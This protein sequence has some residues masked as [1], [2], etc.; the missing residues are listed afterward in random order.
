MY[1]T[2]TGYPRKRFLVLEKGSGDHL[3]SIGATDL[4]D[5]LL[6]VTRFFRSEKTNPVWTP[7]FKNGNPDA[8]QHRIDV[9]RD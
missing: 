7:Y 5:A 8:F 6:Q 9:V 1:S 4:N 2:H 3:F